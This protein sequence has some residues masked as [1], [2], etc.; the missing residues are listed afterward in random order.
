MG[1]G[2]FKYAWILNRL[3]LERSNGM[4]INNRTCK[5]KTPKYIFA[6]INNKKGLIRHWYNNQSNPHCALVIFSAGIERINIEMNKNR[7]TREIIKMAFNV[8]VE[9]MIV[10]INKMDTTEPP[11]SEVCFSTSHS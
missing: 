2:S 1:G 4:F 8:G 6:I 10:G 11:Y 7:R 5:F 3:M 9:Q